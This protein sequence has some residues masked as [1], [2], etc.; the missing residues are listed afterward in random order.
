MLRDTGN[1]PQFSDTGARNI[2]VRETTD[3]IGIGAFDPF[4]NPLSVAP[5]LAPAGSI[6][7]TDGTFKIPGLRNVELTAPYFHNGGEATLLDVVNFYARGGNRG[8]TTNPIKTRDGVTI[9][10]LNPLNFNVVQPGHRPGRGPGRPGR[11]PQ[12]AHRRAGAQSGGAVRP[13]ADLRS[14]RPPGGLDAPSRSSTD[15]A[16]DTFL[17]I[18]AT[19]R[20]GGPPLPGFLE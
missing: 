13:S 12:G 18:P 5:Q 3:D 17:N 2:G 20:N 15:S 7:A 16:V 9:G 10:G 6:I 8:G 1:P 14:E 11:V 4:G 19:G